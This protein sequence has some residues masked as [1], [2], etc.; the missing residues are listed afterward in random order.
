[1]IERC[2]FCI[3]Y[4]QSQGMFGDCNAGM[5]EKFDG[6]TFSTNAACP[7]FIHREK[8]K[9]NVRPLNNIHRQS[10]F[11]PGTGIMSLLF[12]NTI[13]KPTGQ[14][15]DNRCS[16]EKKIPWQNPIVRRKTPISTVIDFESAKK[17][18]LKQKKLNGSL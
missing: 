9:G 8:G 15:G 16:E 6:T 1:M 11:M 14:R 10:Q 3:H 13:L 12:T 18:L 17:E 7:A 2:G 4:K 5:R